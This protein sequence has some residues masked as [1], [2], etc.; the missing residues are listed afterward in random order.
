MR[1]EALVN[2]PTS[3]TT[4]I[5]E[6]SS[7][8]AQ[9]KR[10]ASRAALTLMVG[11]LASRIT[12]FL[13]TSLLNQLFSE[14]I[15][16]AFV[17]AQRVPNLFR[18]LLAEGAL[19]N[20]F[21][22]VYKSL[23]KDEAK[24][25]SG[26]LLGLLLLVN[27]VL[28]AVAYLAT[29]WIVDLFLTDNGNI[30]RTLAAQ[31][32]QIVFP[33]LTMVSLSAWVMGILNAEEAFL[34]PAWAPVSLNIISVV[35]MLLFPDNAVWLAL[36]FV[37]G[38]LVQFL[39]QLPALFKRKLVRLGNSLLENVWHPQLVGVLLLMIPSAFT[40]GGR[41]IVSVITTNILDALPTG[42]TTALGNAELFVS[43]VIGLFA[44]SPTLA[45]YSRL[46]DNA[47][48]APEKFK[49]TLLNGLRLITFLILPAGLILSVLARPMVETLFNWMTILGGTGTKPSVITYSVDALIPFGLA[50][51]PMGLNTLLIRIF[52]IRKRIT[53]VVLITVLYLAL[54]AYLSYA[55]APSMGIAGLSWANVVGQWV[56]LAFLLVFVWRLERFHITELTNQVWRVTLA[57]GLASLATYALSYLPW[58]TGWWSAFGQT[59][60]GV[61]VFGLSYALSSYLLRVSEITQIVQRLRKVT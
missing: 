41:Q 19:T 15:T 26:A 3:N 43:L 50:M 11:T 58:T 2:N 28:L 39:V 5:V 7:T 47:V 23:S 52:Y 6:P 57:A 36:G 51:F 55:F 37:L 14:R 13:R 29:P 48:H 18:E 40:T 4:P 22:P 27:G 12:G 42:S 44:V 49:D 53:T 61:T 34:A 54:Q 17:M 56:Q 31:L 10:N 16:D 33:F 30:D 59:A 24:K 38:G 35:L 46:S 9:P 60:L 32:I 21:I 20:S 25:L 45:F 8:S 1:R